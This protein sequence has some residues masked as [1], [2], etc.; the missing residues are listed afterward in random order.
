MD[1]TG[2]PTTQIF[3]SGVR[4]SRV[5]TKSPKPEKF[6]DSGSTDSKRLK[7]V[8]D[9]VLQQAKVESGTVKKHT[10]NK[11]RRKDHITGLANRE[12]LNPDA[13][14]FIDGNKKPVTIF[15]ANPVDPWKHY[16]WILTYHDLGGDVD[17]ALVRAKPDVLVNIR[18]FTTQEAEQTLSRIQQLPRDLFVEA[19]DAYVT[20]ES[21]YVIFE[22]MHI[23]LSR[24]I[25][26]TDYP[27]PHQVGAIIGQII[28]GIA[29]LENE[30]MEH[31]HLDSSSVLLT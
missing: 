9:E 13:T 17:L 2:R 19:Y 1:K 25:K 22:E 29:Y 8:L 4:P 11:L 20:E 5:R 16:E 31:I 27:T 21:L 30:G 24:M 28:E 23:N 6:R 12:E 18:V 15:A 3:F 14:L 10:N 26:S 7:P